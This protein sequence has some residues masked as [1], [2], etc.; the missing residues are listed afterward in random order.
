[1]S[2]TTTTM[3]TI[4]LSPTT[5]AAAPSVF[6]LA[7]SSMDDHVKAA[8]KML[9]Q[10]V[11]THM[12]QVGAFVAQSAVLMMAG[13]TSGPTALAIVG[14]AFAVVNCCAFAILFGVASTLD[15]CCTALMG[16]Y[17]TAAEKKDIVGAEQAKRNF[18]LWV[19]VALAS[20]V[21]TSIPICLFFA[22]AGGLLSALM[23]LC[24]SESLVK[25]LMPLLYEMVPYV[26]VT[27]MTYCLAKASQAQ[28]RADIPAFATLCSC[29]VGALCAFFIIPTYGNRPGVPISCLLIACS[30]FLVNVGLIVTGVQLEVLKD[31]DANAQ[32]I[33]EEV[34]VS[35]TPSPTTASSPSVLSASQS[36]SPASVGASAAAVGGDGTSKS[37]SVVDHTD[38]FLRTSM[39]FSAAAWGDSLA[40]DR[41]ASFVPLAIKNTIAIAS[42]WCSFEILSAIA[43]LADLE[44][45]RT[46][47]L[48][49]KSENEADSHV[50]VASWSVAFNICWLAF[51]V[52]FAIS[53][54]IA[55]WVGRLLGAGKPEKACLHTRAALFADVLCTSLQWTLLCVFQRQIF[56]L[57]G[58]YE[59]TA[60]YEYLELEAMI[61]VWY[62]FH[63]SDGLQYVLQG[64]FR[65]ANRAGLCPLAVAPGNFLI[66][67]P[68]AYLFAVVL[69]AGG[70]PIRGIVGG[71]TIGLLVENLIL[72]IFMHQ[73]DW[74]QLSHE[75]MTEHNSSPAANEAIEDVQVAVSSPQQLLQLTSPITSSPSSLLQEKAK[76]TEMLAPATTPVVAQ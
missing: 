74:R 72:L 47:A 37:S 66:G 17:H 3:T 12:M 57:Y 7:S 27:S 28:M 75:A 44:R 69:K 22:D 33:E 62:L 16:V 24:Y 15:T 70:H 52:N 38:S 65:G 45:Q 68:C 55:A 19:M 46:L 54:T 36:S 9:P 6:S 53:M 25:Q 59:E 49:G 26:F 61:G 56:A 40:K 21:I 63:C 31:K 1:M 64:V 76:A 42:E 48:D 14:T 5:T 23:L 30:Q 60:K 73:F 29:V 51:A 35:P 34:V 32:V 10:F 58:V 39:F 18:V 41:L 50:L 71:F 4:S 13:R 67:L 11:F 8:R 43:G 20:T 2:P